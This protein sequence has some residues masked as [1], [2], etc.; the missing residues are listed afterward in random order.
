MIPTISRAPY[1]A[2]IQAHVHLFPFILHIAPSIPTLPIFHDTR[3]SAFGFIFLWRAC[4]QSRGRF[5]QFLP[6]T[7]NTVYP[8]SAISFL[9][10]PPCFL[11][12]A[13]VSIFS[14]PGSLCHR[15]FFDAIFQPTL[16]T[17]STFFN[18]MERSWFRGGSHSSFE[19]IFWIS[20]S[21]SCT[22][23]S[24]FFTVPFNCLY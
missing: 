11:S 15:L 24:E 13:F 5:Q 9:P 22:N 10:L 12:Q 2:P 23:F 21:F 18:S 8:R 4:L 20:K 6:V 7:R 14:P 1:N 17:A 16:E 3:A 19:G